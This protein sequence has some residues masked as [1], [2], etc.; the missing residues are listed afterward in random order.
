MTSRK[1]KLPEPDVT[2][3]VQFNVPGSNYW[4]WVKRGGSGN[5]MNSAE[6]YAFANRDEAQ[7]AAYSL[8]GPRSSLRARVVSQPR[9][10]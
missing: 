3:H 4:P 8:M 9:K 6:A 10:P 1:R 5:T 2:W 7:Q